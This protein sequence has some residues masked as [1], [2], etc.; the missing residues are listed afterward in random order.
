MTSAEAASNQA[1]SS[2]RDQVLEPQS[3]ACLYVS[4][5]VI[6]NL[7]KTFQCSCTGYRH[8]PEASLSYLPTQHQVKRSYFAN[9]TNE[10]QINK[11]AIDKY[12]ASPT[13]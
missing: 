7:M 13:K 11:T 2:T 8:T 5:V 9:K 10:P 12:H 4:P 3:Q 6:N 1:G